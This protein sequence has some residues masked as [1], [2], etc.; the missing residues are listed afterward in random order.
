MDDTSLE[1]ENKRLLEVLAGKAKDLIESKGRM[2]ELERREDKF[3]ITD[4]GKQRHT[5]GLLLI[6]Y[7]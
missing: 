5:Y 2:A 3:W 1:I 4:A 6:W 7:R